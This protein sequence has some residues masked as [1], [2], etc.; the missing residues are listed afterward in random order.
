MIDHSTCEHS[1]VVQFDSGKQSRY[2]CQACGVLLYRRRP[3]SPLRTYQC[4]YVEKVDTMQP[5]GTVSK[6]RVYSCNAPGVK[7]GAND[8]AYCEVHGGTRIAEKA[9]A[10][11]AQLE[12]SRKAQAVAD[13][14]M[15]DLVV[16]QH[17]EQ[18]RN[19][20]TR[21]VHS[22]PDQLGGVVFF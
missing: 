10:K 20:P 9:K 6:S 2:K 3:N 16:A 4:K 19:Q 7:L 1:H 22:S 21:V 5:D 14:A 13:Q 8:H 18:A 15:A 11:T 17:R 12:R